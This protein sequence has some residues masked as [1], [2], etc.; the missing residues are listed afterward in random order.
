MVINRHIFGLF[1]S[2]GGTCIMSAYPGRVAVRGGSRAVLRRK[3]WLFAQE[4]VAICVRRGGY[5][6]F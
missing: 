2:L 3:G 4:G 6:G 1:Y 5:F